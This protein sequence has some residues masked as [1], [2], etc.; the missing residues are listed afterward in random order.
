LENLKYAETV[1]EQAHSRTCRGELEWIAG[2]TWIEA[3][4]TPEIEVSI[5]YKDDGPDSATWDRVMISH[6]V[7]RGFTLVGNPASPDVRYFEFVAGGPT[8]DR[9]NEIFRQV[10][11]GPR[12]QQFE[13][14]MKTLSKA[15]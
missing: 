6:P 10:F 3:K 11:L 1:I 2:R 15:G 4:L 13:A 12:Q 8:L 14:V 9:V 5:K 7:G